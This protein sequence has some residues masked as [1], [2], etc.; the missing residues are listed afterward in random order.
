MIGLVPD[1]VGLYDDLSAFDNSDFYGKLY[2]CPEERRKK[3]IEHFLK[4]LGLWESKDARA[5]SFSKGMKQKLALT[6]GLVHEPKIL[7]MDEPIA[8][9]DP[10]SAKS[11]RDFII[12]VQISRNYIA[13]FFRQNKAYGFSHYVLIYGSL[14]K[15]KGVIL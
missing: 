14:L 2:K 7:F 1:N 9:L 4:M 11:I 15:Y 3:N 12:E 6:R 10:E 8:N 5:G 13:I